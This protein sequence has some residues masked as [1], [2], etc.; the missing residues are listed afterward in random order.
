MS[1]YK[2]IVLAGGAGTRLYPLTAGTSKQL[3]PV[4]DKPMIYYPISVLMIA[5]IKE[6][7]IITTPEDLENYK[8]LL[9]DGSKL[10]IIFQYAVQ[11][12]PKGIADAIIVGKKFIGNDNVC[13][14]LGDNIFHGQGLF[15][16]LKKAISVQKGATIFAYKVMDPKRFGI[17]EF[18][19]KFKAISIE[20]KPKNPK[21]NY[22]VT[23]L[24]LYDNTVVS[25]VNS[26]KPSNRGELEITDVNEYYLTKKK[27]NVE[28]F[29]RG[30]AWLDTGTQDSLVDA[31]QYIQAI[32]NRQGF[33]VACLE[34]ISW[35]NK[36]ISTKQLLKIGKK[37]NNTTYG[38]YL[39]EIAKEK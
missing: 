19:N 26:L 8:L 5:G 31:S 23:G 18:N 25:I 37:I 24:Y 15:E 3:L 38:K 39:L 36:W 12:K 11:E 4:Y 7:L 33:K 34:E 20:E 21:S 29:G 27:L 9:G 1:K 2:G 14:I 32:E 35:R 30:F 22:A 17:V 28:I 6:I 13:L 10:G 16:S